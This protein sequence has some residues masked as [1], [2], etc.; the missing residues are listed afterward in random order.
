M[1]A[2]FFLDFYQGKIFHG[3]AAFS[4]AAHQ[5]LGLRIRKPGAD[6]D[7]GRGRMIAF[8]AQEA[9]SNCVAE[10]G[11]GEFDHKGTIGGLN[12][13]F[14]GSLHPDFHII[15]ILGF[16]F[17]QFSVYAAF[18]ELHDLLEINVLYSSGAAQLH[19]I[20]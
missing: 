16:H 11:G 14:H 2:A 9:G 15:A 3:A 17:H 12:G 18:N 20:R 10:Q 1:S 13:Y 4:Q 8:S 19:N 5:L 7:L 6:F